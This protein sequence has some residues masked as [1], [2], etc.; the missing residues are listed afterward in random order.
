LAYE[1]GTATDLA[2]LITKLNTFATSNGW[3]GDELDT[4]N[5]DWAI[6]KNTVFVSARWDTATPQHLALYQAL[7]FDGAG[8]LPGDH[9]DDSGNGYNDTSSHVDT[10]LDNERHV[11]DL[12]DGP[13]PSYHF[14]EN[15]SNPAYIHVVVEVS[16]GIYRHFGFGELSKVGTW[17]GG[18]YVYAHYN[19][20]GTTNKLSTIFGTLLDGLQVNEQFCATLHCEGLTNQDASSKWGIVWGT[21]TITPSNDSGGNPRERIQGGFRGGPTARA[22]GNF[23]GSSLTGLIPAYKIGLWHLD[24]DNNRMRLLGYQADVRGINIRNFSSGQEVTIGS[25]TW[26]MFPLLLRSTDNVA[27]HTDY[28]G[29]AYKKV[30]A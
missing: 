18:E 17:T 1:T 25:D 2:D 28:S 4:G 23:N 12:G 20:N 3:T 22:F 24:N 11:T 26:V 16:T 19:N 9:T 5:G 27:Y 13:F 7:A 8:T 21:T 14:F 15:D 30:T 10:I 29:I 6:S